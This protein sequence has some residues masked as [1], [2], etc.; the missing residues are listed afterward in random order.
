MTL[1]EG[2]KKLEWRASGRGGL[3]SNNLVLEDGKKNTRGSGDGQQ[4]HTGCTHR[5]ARQVQTE[6]MTEHSVTDTHTRDS[7]AHGSRNN[8]LS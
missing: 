3:R 2:K 4:T 5:V 7:T 6:L 8:V 1:D